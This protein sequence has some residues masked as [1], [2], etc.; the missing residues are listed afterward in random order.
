MTV[1]NKQK[2][3]IATVTVE[4]KNSS[5]HLMIEHP[6]MKVI[7]ARIKVKEIVAAITTNESFS[8][9]KLWKFPI[10]L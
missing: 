5:C 4:C 7:V 10:L 3:T 8:R 1:L 6:D 9:P 2:E